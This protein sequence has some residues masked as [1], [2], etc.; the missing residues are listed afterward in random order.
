MTWASEALAKGADHVLAD[1]ITGSTW[2]DEH[3]DGR[4]ATITGAT[5][6][7]A[8]PPGTFSNYVSFDGVDDVATSPIANFGQTL[9]DF[10][11]EFVV[12]WLDTGTTRFLAGVLNDNDSI[13]CH[14]VGNDDE[15]GFAGNHFSVLIRESSSPGTEHLH[16]GSTDVMDILADGEWH[17]LVVSVVE[18][19]GTSPDV[20]FWVDK[21]EATDLEVDNNQV[22]TDSWSDF[23]F[24]WMDG[25]RNLRGT[26]DG[27]AEMDLAGRALYESAVTSQTDIDDLYD[28]AFTTQDPANLQ[29]SVSGSDVTLTWD[30]SF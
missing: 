29:A 17:H 22:T 6:I 14:V 8:S 30:A 19:L 11:V 20:R 7:T 3:G 24:D 13:A 9:R 2:A 26:A 28:A 21:V 16:V 15:F 4:D 23:E 1:D 12:R 27:H 10:T 18:A 25:A 5:V